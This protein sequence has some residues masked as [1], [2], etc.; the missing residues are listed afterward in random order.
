MRGEISA[1]ETLQVHARVQ[2]LN[3]G[4]QQIVLLKKYQSY[5]LLKNEFEP[6]NSSGI[7]NFFAPV[8]NFKCVQDAVTALIQ[9]LDQNGV[10]LMLCSTC[11]ILKMHVG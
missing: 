4:A 1:Q 3:R 5:L 11:L 10:R 8:D 9:R 2:T 6:H 7:S